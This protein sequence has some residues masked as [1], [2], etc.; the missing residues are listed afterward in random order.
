MKSDG[1]TT[2]QLQPQQIKITM[3]PGWPT[4]LSKASRGWVGGPWTLGETVNFPLSYLHLAAESRTIYALNSET[5]S[6]GL[7]IAYSVNC[8]GRFQEGP[9]CSGVSKSETIVFNVSL[10]LEECKTQVPHPSI[11]FQ[12]SNC[13]IRTTTPGGRR[14]EHWDR[15]AA[16]CGRRLHHPRLRLRV[17]EAHQP[18]PLFVIILSVEL[19]QAHKS[20]YL[21]NCCATQMHLTGDEGARVRRVGVAGVRGLRVREGARRRRLLLRPRPLRR[22]LRRRA[23]RPVPHVRRPPSHRLPC[24]P[25]RRF[26]AAGAPPSRPARGRASACAG[27]ATATRTRSVGSSASATTGTA[28]WPVPSPAPPHLPPPTNPGPGPDG[29][30]CGGKGKCKCGVCNCEAGWVGDACD[31]P[32]D[33]DGCKVSAHSSTHPHPTALSPALPPASLPFPSLSPLHSRLG[34]GWGW[35]RL[36]GRGPL[37]LRIVRV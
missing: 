26:H 14:G 15:G 13:L 11:H 6:S 36:L 29:E 34:P 17:R 18:G 22:R 33:D 24:I 30:L 9:Q 32:E 8:K 3:K 37:R 7:N 28:P 23:G 21:I 35:E 2:V 20:T 1:A 4:A 31:C 25:R 5:G 16:R 12:L 19:Y 27:S 10:T